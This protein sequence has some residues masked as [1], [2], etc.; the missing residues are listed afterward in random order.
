MLSSL[1]FTLGTLPERAN[2][3]YS[4]DPVLYHPSILQSTTT[5]LSSTSPVHQKLFAKVTTDLKIL[6]S[7]VDHFQFLSLLTYPK[8]ITQVATTFLKYNQPLAPV[9]SLFPILFLPFL[10]LLVPFL[11]SPFLHLSI[12]RC[13][14]PWF[15][16]HP[17]WVI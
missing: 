11:D 14:S 10:I 1:P 15:K 9:R 16:P 13:Q 12:K 8:Y 4:Q 3:L 6:Q 7:S 5:L 17:L 2:S